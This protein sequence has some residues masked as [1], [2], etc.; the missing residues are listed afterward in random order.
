MQNQDTLEV[1]GTSIL[2][3]CVILKDEARV[4]LE[5]GEVLY[6]IDGRDKER[7]SDIQQEFGK[8]ARLWG[9]VRR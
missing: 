8:N 2:Q 1:E 7:D 4:Y 3:Y 9:G 5:F 6:S